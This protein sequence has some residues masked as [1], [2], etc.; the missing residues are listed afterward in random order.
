MEILEIILTVCDDLKDVLFRGVV[1]DG[2]VFGDGLYVDFEARNAGTV[3]I[4]VELDLTGWIELY[5]VYGFSDMIG[6][7]WTGFNLKPSLGDKKNLLCAKMLANNLL[8]RINRAYKFLSD[9]I[10]KLGG[11]VAK[12]E[13][14][15]L[16]SLALVVGSDL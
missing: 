6:G 5:W 2:V 7:G 4:D 8:R 11:P 1:T 15:A 9:G 12:E 13:H 14:A 3:A 10:L 16:D